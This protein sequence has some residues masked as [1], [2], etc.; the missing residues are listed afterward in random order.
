MNR[1]KQ[2]IWSAVAALLLVGVA[3]STGLRPP[4]EPTRS[5]LAAKRAVRAG[6]VLAQ[7]DFIAVK[8]PVKFVID[9]YVTD[10]DVVIGA[11]TDRELSP[12][13][14]IDNRWLNTRPDGVAYPDGRT[15]GRLYTLRLQAEQA[16]GFW[17]AA[18]NRV[19]VHLIPRG[20]PLE[21]LPD[22][23]PNVRVLAMIGLDQPSSQNGALSGAP[24]PLAGGTAL[25]CLDVNTAQ[26]RVLARAEPCC[27]IKLV[28][29]N[30]PE[31]R[32]TRQPFTDGRRKAVDELVASQA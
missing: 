29:I 9:E 19:D 7:E 11:V 1:K 20:E 16:N 14:L 31:D 21:D 24:A 22:I 5:V 26:A 8:L 28:P 30:E 27:V 3:Y 2:I 12:G 23:L 13:Q 6:Q 10:P 4:D 15:D 25:V 32:P 17:L 18:G